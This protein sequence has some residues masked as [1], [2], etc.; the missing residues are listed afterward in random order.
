MRC[1]RCN[2][3]LKVEPWRSKGIGAICYKKIQIEEARRNNGD[4]DQ[5]ETYKGGDIWI[6][7]ITSGD[8]AGGVRTNVPRIEYKHSPTGFNFGYAGSGP[9]DFAL[10]VMLMFCKS[11]EDAHR[12]YQQFKFQFVASGSSERLVIPAADIISW[13]QSQGAESKNHL[14][15]P[16]LNLAL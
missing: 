3:I 11:R 15:N 10:N 12:I 1:S 4:S 2:R 9:A 6:E 14:V 8:A 7:R 13:I 16:Q 5:I